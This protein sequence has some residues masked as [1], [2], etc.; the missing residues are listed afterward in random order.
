MSPALTLSCRSLKGLVSPFIA[1]W[2]K[3]IWMIPETS[4]KTFCG[5]TRQKLNCDS[6][7]IWIKLTAAHK[8]ITTTVRHGDG[9]VM[10]WAAAEFCSW[11]SP[12]E[13]PEGASTITSCS[14][15]KEHLGNAAGRWSKTSKFSLKKVFECLSPDLNQIKK[16]TKCFL[17]TQGSCIYLQRCW[18]WKGTK[19]INP[20]MLPQ[21][22]SRNKF[23][24]CL[25]FQPLFL[26]A[27]VSLSGLCCAHY[28]H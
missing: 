17:T 16:K 26:L 14:A 15:A 18:E 3:N 5:L 6:R 19:N 9:S 20:L 2:P 11:M 4:G 28:N 21:Y 7:Y 22:D 23:K 25:K 10:G 8:K 12:P 13:K 27:T 1:H 24:L